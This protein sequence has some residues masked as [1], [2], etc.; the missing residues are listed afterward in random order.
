M[1]ALELAIFA[2]LLTS[3]WWLRRQQLHSLEQQRILLQRLSE[4]VMAWRG[5][6][7]IP[8]NARAVIEKLVELPMNKKILRRFAQQ[9]VL[10]QQAPL[11]LEENPFWL[12]KQ[13]LSDEQREA[14]D[15]LLLTAFLAFTYSDWI[16][17]PFVRR[18]RVGGL[19]RQ[20]QAEIALETVSSRVM[21]RALRPVAA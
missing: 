10:Q 16:I 8:Q 9:Q 20:T 2:L 21:G 5:K 18:L 13:E 14:F 17:G 1:A 11:K 12:A 3:I 15:Y 4:G 6:P 7:G 19:S